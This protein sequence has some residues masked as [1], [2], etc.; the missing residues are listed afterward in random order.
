MHA[1]V[2]ADGDLAGKPELDRAWPGWDD[3]VGL[4]IAADGGARGGAALGRTLD[5]VVGDGDSLGDEALAA[6]AVEG[7]AIERSPAAKDETDTELAI[8][9]ALARGAGRIT[10]LGAFGGPRLDHELANVALLAHPALRGTDCVLIGRSAR[11][12]LLDAP[13]PGGASVRVTL[14][15]PRGALVSLL[16]LDAEV[17]GVTTEGLEYPLRSEPLPLGPARGL[18]NVRTRGSATVEL[19]HGRLLIVESAATLD[20]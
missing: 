4:V 20:R 18:S 13:G 2:L 10:V 1:L 17:E 12:R 3:D 19:R 15:G 5:L 11:V 9:A 8:L 16:P 7:V 14:P 6:L